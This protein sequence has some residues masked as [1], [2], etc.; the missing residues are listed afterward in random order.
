[1]T[2]HIYRTKILD[3]QLER[4]QKADNSGLQAA[5]QARQIIGI[6]QQNSGIEPD[7]LRRK[8][9]KHGELRLHN[10]RKYDLGGGY[11]LLC[12]RDE[13]HLIFA[14]VGNHDDCHQWLENH[15]N[16][17]IG[18]PDLLKSSEPVP[19]TR[20]QADNSP[21]GRDQSSPPQESDP[22]EEELYSRLDEKILRHVFNGISR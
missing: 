8:R 13:R 5:R 11:R 10:C 20:T 19:F 4:L 1:M 18:Q 17:S 12:L 9:T 7:S 16:T 14:Y 22:Y 2:Q 15:R 3:K 21:V 6:L